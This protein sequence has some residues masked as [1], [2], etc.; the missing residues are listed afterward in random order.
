MFELP[1]SLSARMRWRIRRTLMGY[2]GHAMSAARVRSGL[3]RL[4]DTPDPWQMTSE[5][6]Q[7][8]F[9]RTNGIIARELIGSAAQVGSLLEIGCGEGHQ[10]EY[11]SALCRQLTGIDIV[12][13]AIERA[14]ARSAAIEWVL[15]D[16]EDQPWSNSGRHFDIVTA[17]ECLYAF[18]DVPRA[19]RLM[20]LLGDACLVTYFH[21]AAHAVERPLRAM[22]LEGGESFVYEDVTWTAVWWRPHSR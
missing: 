3:E 8:R 19:L 14:R 22:P 4:Y 10:S 15:G 21:G 18:R 2:T 7:F 17:C 5:K 9:A 6:E 12:P 20:S 1:L 11:L 16:V 13:K